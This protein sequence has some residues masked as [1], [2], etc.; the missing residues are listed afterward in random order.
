MA[1]HKGEVSGFAWVKP[2]WWF[3]PGM[4]S[5][6]VGVHVGRW[7]HG[8]GS[9]LWTQ[10]EQIID[11]APEWDV[12]GIEP[13]AFTHIH[14]DSDMGKG[15]ASRRGFTPTGSVLLAS[16]LETSKARLDDL[17]DAEE[18]LRRQGVRIMLITEA[19]LRDDAFLRRLYACVDA[20]ERTSPASQEVHFP[21]FD[22][23]RRKLQEALISGRQILWAAQDGERPIGIASLEVLDGERL[24][25]GF[26]GV[27]P[28]D[29]GRG[30]AK[31]LKAETIRWARR[32][33][34]LWM[35]TSSEAGNQPMLRIN[36]RIGYERLPAVVEWSKRLS[37]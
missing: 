8:I 4:L 6:F 23:W 7:G 5:A 1:E 17:Q 16:R 25:N 14:E 18:N 34:Y 19:H 12:G 32:H 35:V 15:F 9:A 26:T 24:E 3:G 10:V 13:K 30:V 36:E 28:S 20:T 2:A 37:S 31:A 29:R 27:L 21:A 11:A 33:G 22:E